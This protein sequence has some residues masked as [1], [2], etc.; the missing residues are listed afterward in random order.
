[1][2]DKNIKFDIHSAKRIIFFVTLYTALGILY[3]SLKGTIAPWTD[4]CLKAL[5]ILLLIGLLAFSL[6]GAKDRTEV[7]LPMAALFF[8][9]LGDSA[10]EVPFLHGDMKFIFMMLFFAI[11]HVFYICSFC[12]FIKGKRR[13]PAVPLLLIYYAVILAILHPHMVA[14]A[15]K[16]GACI[17]MTLILA[18][19]MCASLQKREGLPFFVIG[20]V[21]FILSDSI[22]AY[23]KFVAPLPGRDILVMGT[24]YAAQLLLNFRLIR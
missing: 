4:V 22:L 10:G 9:F 13:T 14:G 24:Y 20:A 12:R 11:A 8:S 15:V 21:L 18:M 2:V 19:G 16:A 7:L 1:M 23:C 5:P 3:I 17:Y 6:K